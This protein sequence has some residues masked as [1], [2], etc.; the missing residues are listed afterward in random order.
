MLKNR[1][2]LIFAALMAAGFFLFAGP[3]APHAHADSFSDTDRAKVGKLCASK[4]DISQNSKK[5]ED[6][7]VL[8]ACESGY[9]MAITHPH[10]AGPCGDSYKGDNKAL[11]A[12]KSIGFPL[13][14][15][16]SLHIKTPGA[17]GGKDKSPDDSCAGSDC[18]ATPTGSGQNCDEKHCDL[19]S[20]YVNPL[21]RLLS[22]LVGLVVAGSLVMGGVQYAASSGDS[23]KISAAKSRISNSLLAFVAYAFLYAFLN[24]LIPGGL[25]R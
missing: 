11:N 23:Q 18:S 8:G 22:I 6:Q 12:C 3:P 19:V 14:K 7:K 13:G 10:D 25:S 17:G 15:A 21:I 20:L 16:N 4:L 1:K 9:F 5:K 2:R 24:F